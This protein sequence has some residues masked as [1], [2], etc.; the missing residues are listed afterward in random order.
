MHLRAH[1][2][3]GAD[4]SV[5]FHHLTIHQFSASDGTKTFGQAASLLTFGSAQRLRF[6]NVRPELHSLLLYGQLARMHLLHADPGAPCR[7]CTKRHVRL[8][9]QIGHFRVGA[10][11]LLEELPKS[12][13]AGISTV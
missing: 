11:R 12:L 4:S 7:C 13:Q 5:H 8:D 2:L 9:V 3:L 10:K 6:L 1:C